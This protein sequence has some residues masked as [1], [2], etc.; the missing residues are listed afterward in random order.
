MNYCKFENTY[1][2]LREC[3]EKWDNVSNDSEEEYKTL[4][5]EMS[6]DIARLG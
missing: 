4:L 2:D 5:I 6:K 1:D 3:W